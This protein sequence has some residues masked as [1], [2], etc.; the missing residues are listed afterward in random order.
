MPADDI[1]LLPP[2]LRGKEEKIRKRAPRKVWEIRMTSPQPK[3]SKLKE[4]SKTSWWEEMKKFLTQPLGKKA[5]PMPLGSMAP[6]KMPVF[7]Y[8]KKV[9]AKPAEKPKLIE[10]KTL[11]SKAEP[12]KKVSF[13]SRV[14]KTKK[15]E[16]KIEARMIS[17]RDLPSQ[18]KEISPSVKKEAVKEIAAWSKVTEPEKIQLKPAP[19]MSFWSK[20]FKKKERK[21]TPS[22]PSPQKPA[23]VSFFEKIFGPKIKPARKETPLAPVLHKKTSFFQKFFSAKE[24]PTK[25]AKSFK[26]PPL[27]AG[28]K[29]KEKAP[30]KPKKFKSPSISFIP[31]NEVSAK[32]KFF[33]KIFL[34]EIVVLLFC[35]L[36]GFSY[37]ILLWYHANLMTKSSN[38]EIKISELKEKIAR[39][40]KEE[41]MM[42]IDQKR[43]KAAQVLLDQHIYWS[44]LFDLLGRYTVD[45]VY[46]KDFAVSD[47]EKITLQAVGADFRSM[48]R[49]LLVFS[50]A[51]DYIKDVKISSGSYSITGV[52]FTIN[53]TVDK[54]L[55]YKLSYDNNSLK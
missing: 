8:E 13:W 36:L 26:T 28:G 10:I 44:N 18:K 43:I 46:Y 6:L 54:A 55:F 17:T 37:L 50:Q 40:Q 52:S 35:F 29:K 22:V 21:I 47:F 49:Q 19:K 34:G 38:L 23:K 32:L 51:K 20:I 11:P 7:E 30:L 2:D 9:L 33:K 5:R 24:E 3:Q 14:F 16:L 45:D 48:A 27:S 15:H 42:L 53:L 41:E 12:A 1:N 4:A 25:P 39:N 31:E